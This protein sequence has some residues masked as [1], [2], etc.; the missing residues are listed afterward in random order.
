MILQL[1]IATA[2]ALGISSID[3][4]TIQETAMSKATQAET[5]GTGDHMLMCYKT[6]EKTS[7]MNKIC[8]YDCAGSEVAITIRS[9]EYCPASL[10]R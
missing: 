1:A 3:G 4:A 2:V 6:G 10:D 9:N 8:Y 7:G 5:R